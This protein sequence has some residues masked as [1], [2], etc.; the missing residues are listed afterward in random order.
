MSVLNMSRRRQDWQSLSSALWEEAM[1]SLAIGLTILALST[2]AIA[3]EKSNT[4][5]MATAEKR[6]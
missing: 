2:P 4:N 6:S 3:Q 1:R 5:A